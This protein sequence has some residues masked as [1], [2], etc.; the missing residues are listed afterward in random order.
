MAVW[1]DQQ[2]NRS[3]PMVTEAFKEPAQTN[4]HFIYSLERDQLF[5]TDLL[6]GEQACH[7]VPAYQFIL[8]CSWR[9]DVGTY[10]ILQ[11]LSLLDEPHRK[12]T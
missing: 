4:P 12:L 9:V 10:G 5:R 7:R 11:A 2:I 8:E 6:T 1:T 3:T